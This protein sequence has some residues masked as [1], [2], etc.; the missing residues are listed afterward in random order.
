MH[1]QAYNQSDEVPS[2]RSFGA[3]LTAS[4]E[5]NVPC[6]RLRRR[7]RALRT[8]DLV[9]LHGEPVEPH[10][11]RN[12]RTY[13]RKN[14]RS[15]SYLFFTFPFTLPRERTLH[16]EYAN[17]ILPREKGI[18][19]FDMDRPIPLFS[20]PYLVSPSCLSYE[21]LSFPIFIASQRG[22][23]KCISSLTSPGFALANFIPEID[24]TIVSTSKVSKTSTPVVREL[25]AV[26]ASSTILLNLTA[27]L[28]VFCASSR[29]KFQA[30]P[31][32]F[33]ASSFRA[34]VVF[35]FSEYICATRG[36]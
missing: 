10:E 22:K 28:R 31:S 9:D 36:A 25:R 26:S 16:I 30:H 11:R 13:E 1:L 21:S 32:F 8:A 17:C 7:L 20:H 2:L 15:V 5:A 6:L 24:S 33:Q 27:S 35:N 14:P 23:N 19:C 3:H 34:K 18:Q 4:F 29:I 12:S